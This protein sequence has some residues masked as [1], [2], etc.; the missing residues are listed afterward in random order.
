[1][2]QRKGWTT[3]KPATRQRYERNGITRQSYEAGASLAKARGHATTPEHGTPGAR[4]KFWA[5]R[6]VERKITDFIPNFE[7]FPLTEQNRIGEAY[8]K[9]MFQKWKGRPLDAEERKLRGI[10]KR[11]RKLYRRQTDEQVEYQMDWFQAYQEFG[12]DE[13]WGANEWA[14]FRSAYNST[15]SVSA[16]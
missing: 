2:T 5:N 9:G 4:S 8:I 16:A 1:M 12:E 15:A 7:D 3:L 11:D 14:D 6:A 10:G 13:T